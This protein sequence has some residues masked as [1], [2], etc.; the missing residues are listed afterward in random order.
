MREIH[1]R[2]GAA[3]AG[4]RS[5][6]RTSRP[7]P[8][9]EAAVCRSTSADDFGEERIVVECGFDTEVEAGDGCEGGP[10]VGGAAACGV[11]L[12][13]DAITGYSRGFGQEFTIS[14]TDTFRSYDGKE[15]RPLLWFDP[16]L[17]LFPV[18]TDCI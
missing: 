11:G 3:P 13:E 5:D 6:V 8:R 14:L 7:W 2:R 9:V 10:C 1:A 4:K 15:K 16:G 12:S 18:G 17:T